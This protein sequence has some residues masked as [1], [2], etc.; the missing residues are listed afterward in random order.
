MVSTINMETLTFAL[1]YVQQGFSIFPLK[2]GSKKPILD[3]W[4]PYK[5]KIAANEQL[6]IWFSN[7][8]A[9]NNIA[10]VTG[11]ISSIF[12]LDIDGEDG[13][14]HFN[15]ILESIDDDGL[16][17]ALKYTLCIRTGSGN[18]NIVIG[19]REEEFTSSDDKIANSVLWRSKNGNANH[20]E[21]RL[22][23]ESG[24]I[25]APPSVHPNGNRYEIINPNIASYGIRLIGVYQCVL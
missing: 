1:E 3:S 16:K 19:F 5:R 17:T 14:D 25:V 13:S 21:I 6:E 23:G 24:Y 2:P 20:N 18:T 7:G 4:D 22:K 11:R 12:A 9:C 8:H 10:I 15:K